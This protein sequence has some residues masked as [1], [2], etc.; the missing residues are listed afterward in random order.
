[1][2]LANYSDLKNS[3]RSWS[4]K[5]TSV[6]TDD[7]VSDMIAIAEAKINRILTDPNGHNVVALTV[8][9]GDPLVVLPSDINEQS[10][11]WYDYGGYRKVIDPFSPAQ[12][13][14]ANGYTGTGP[15]LFYNVEQANKIRLTPAPDAAYS[16]YL[17]YFAEVPNL[18]GS[19]TT[20]WM[21]TKYPD[22]YLVAC[23]EQA[24]RFMK[25]LTNAKI[26]EADW[27]QQ[28]SLQMMK[29]NYKQYPPGSYQ[30]NSGNYYP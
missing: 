28:I 14:S 23:L 3:I 17:S 26:M 19:N 4:A 5:S 12:L 25:N 18:S 27:N 15:P 13:A 9:A 7:I 1:M 8:T 10:V 16:M 22:I 29:N 2:A 21:L 24:E 11:I 6:F 20:N 30:T